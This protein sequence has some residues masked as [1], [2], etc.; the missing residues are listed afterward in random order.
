MNEM[1]ISPKQKQ[2]ITLDLWL[3]CEGTWLGEMMQLSWRTKPTKQ[4]F[5]THC[6]SVDT[7][8]L[9]TWKMDK[10]GVYVCVCVCVCVCGHNI[11]LDSSL[12]KA[13]HGQDYLQNKLN[14]FG[15]ILNFLSIMRLFPF[16][17]A[18]CPIWQQFSISSWFVFAIDTQQMAEWSSSGLSKMVGV[19]LQ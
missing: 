2:K 17:K 3:F 12:C 13:G 7:S 4:G 16:L 6:A 18:T 11:H 10:L 19:E 8:S 14:F 15:T 1:D 5:F 9:S